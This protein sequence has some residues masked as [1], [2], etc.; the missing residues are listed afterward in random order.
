MTRDQVNNLSR[1][2]E[3]TLSHITANPELLYTQQFCQ[4]LRELPPEKTEKAMRWLG[5]IQGVLWANRLYS[6]DELKD[7]NSLAVEEKEL[8]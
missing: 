7:H 8:S 4:R 2:Y 6:I 3:N 1:Y 5:F